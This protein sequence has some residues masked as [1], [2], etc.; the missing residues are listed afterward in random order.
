MARYTSANRTAQSDPRKLH[1]IMISHSAFRNPQRVF[2]TKRS[3]TEMRSKRNVRTMRIAARAYRPRV[4]PTA[5]GR[6]IGLPSAW[7]IPQRAET[8]HFV[9]LRNRWPDSKIYDLSITRIDR[10]ILESR[11]TQRSL[12][13]SSLFWHMT[14]LPSCRD[15]QPSRRWSLS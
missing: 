13:D 12:F 8:P 2:E 9:G 6:A 7:L 10:R 11:T 14:C 1:R 15:F 5:Y 4:A 3:P